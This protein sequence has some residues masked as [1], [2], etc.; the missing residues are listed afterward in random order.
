MPSQSPSKSPSKSPSNYPSANPST[1]P[2]TTSPTKVPTE[3]PTAKTLVIGFDGPTIAP[4][5]IPTTAT[6]TLSKND[7]TVNE[8]AVSNEVILGISNIII[9]MLSIFLFLLICLIGI[10]FC[11][12]YRKKRYD[13]KQMTVE[14]QTKNIASNSMK[15][16]VPASP[17]H[18]DSENVSNAVIDGL[19]QT[20]AGERHDGLNERSGDGLDVLFGT[21]TTPNGNRIKTHRAALSLQYEDM[22][23]NDN[24][25]K[26]HHKG[27]ADI[28]T[29]EYNEEQNANIFSM[30]DNST[31][32]SKSIDNGIN[33]TT[34]IGSTIGDQNE[35]NPKDG[36]S[37][38]NND[39]V[40]PT[41][42]Q[43]I[44]DLVCG[45]DC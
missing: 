4:T 27:T 17:L 22:Y 24:D 43:S 32:Y 2:F 39:K 26:P 11:R 36:N 13:T 14:M 23:K 18:S 33:N 20:T 31:T 41:K 30:D 34:A 9:L 21:D 45:V 25:I 3:T 7:V 44:G 38:I 16:S 37:Y 5:N 29:I 35:G 12:K 19:M 28:V 6:A 1:S 42:R 10:Y 40:I 15:H 8:S